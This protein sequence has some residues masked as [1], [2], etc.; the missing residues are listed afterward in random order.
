[1]LISDRGHKGTEQ[2]DELIPGHPA[3]WNCAQHLVQPAVESD[4]AAS[5]AVGIRVRA[6]DDACQLAH[7]LNE[8]LPLETVFLTMRSCCREDK[9]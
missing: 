2:L 8:K 5:V 4:P 1:V 7:I 3:L 9:S 6:F